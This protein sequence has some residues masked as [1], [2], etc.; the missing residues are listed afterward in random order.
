MIIRSLHKEFIYRGYNVEDHVI[1]ADPENFAKVTE[2]AP[3]LIPNTFRYDLQ[4]LPQRA[5]EKIIESKCIS[6]RF[7][8]DVKVLPKWLADLGFVEFLSLP[9]HMIKKLSADMLPQSLETLRVTG[10]QQCRFSR[11]FK[12]HNISSLFAL[13]G[14]VLFNENNFTSLKNVH[15]SLDKKR[16]M[17]NYLNSNLHAETLTITPTRNSEELNEIPKKNLRFLRLINGS[18]TNLDG[19][20]DME[21]LTNLHLQYLPKLESINAIGKLPSLKEISV[22]YCNYLKDLTVFQEIPSL[23]KLVFF[24]C[25]K[26][27]FSTMKKEL[28]HRGLEELIFT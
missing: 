16:T 13:E 8:T 25:N 20:I 11:L 9:S 12:S 26:L 17:L 15:I 24:G 14:P 21:L 22:G 3:N 27:D 18:I 4:N 7:S 10:E 2:Y 23:Q 6:F 1:F 28:K 5:L 19:L